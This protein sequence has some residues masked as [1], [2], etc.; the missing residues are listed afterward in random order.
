VSRLAA[1]RAQGRIFRATG[2]QVNSG[3]F[4]EK[5]NDYEARSSCRASLTARRHGF[6]MESCEMAGQGTKCV[7]IHQ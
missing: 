1:L 4:T 5:L 7:P 3:W 2:S 6:G